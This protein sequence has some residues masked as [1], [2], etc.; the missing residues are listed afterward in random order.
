MWA[1]KTVAWYVNKTA[2][3]LGVLTELPIGA[4]TNT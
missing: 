1:D 2:H 4:L 3:V